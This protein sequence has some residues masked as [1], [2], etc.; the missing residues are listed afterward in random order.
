MHRDHCG[1]ELDIHLGV[2]FWHV[3]FTFAVTLYFNAFSTTALIVHQI[4]CDDS[5]SL[6]AFV[7]KLQFSNRCS[8]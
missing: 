4:N 2:R 5:T 8:L 3:A 7:T 6:L 1:E